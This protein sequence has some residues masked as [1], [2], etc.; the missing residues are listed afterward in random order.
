M[1]ASSTPGPFRRSW[2]W[3]KEFA[4]DVVELLRDLIPP[5]RRKERNEE[6]EKHKSRIPDRDEDQTREREQ[7]REQGRAP[8]RDE[9]HDQ[10][11]D[12]EPASEREEELVE[13]EASAQPERK[14][15]REELAAMQDAVRQTARDALWEAQ[16]RAVVRRRQP[17]LRRAPS[18]AEAEIHDAVASVLADELGG[19]VGSH[20]DV[21]MEV[22][23][24]PGDRSISAV[25]GPKRVTDKGTVITRMDRYPVDGM[26]FERRRAGGA[27]LVD[28]SGSMDLSY[29]AVA[30]AI[31]EMPALTIGRYSGPRWLSGGVGTLCVL[32]QD[33]HLG[34]LGD[35]TVGGGGNDV[36]IEA[37]AW[38]SKQPEPRVWVSDGQVCGGLV[39]AL[40]PEVADAT[41]RSLCQ[42]KGI[43]R[44]PTFA[45]AVQVL[46]RGIDRGV[47]V[48][49]RDPDFLPSLA[50]G[51]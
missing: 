2:N 6:Q 8:E 16:D 42:R 40:G 3:V 23:F 51:F 41:I 43:V 30:T 4:H 34:E 27:I 5:L 1:D 49:S 19:G 28:H 21:G 50:D 14:S 44:V 47:S 22:H 32:A 46:R 10:G 45:E 11:R 48:T 36:D 24:H 12:Q 17:V 38:L 26:V 39:D 9:E 20:G 37:L 18:E 33:G 29:E 25:R 13:D 35:C 15:A 31:E 7:G